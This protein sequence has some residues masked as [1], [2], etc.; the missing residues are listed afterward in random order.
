MDLS[1]ILAISGYPGLFKMIGQ[2]KG[3]VVVE[4]LI[5]GKRM[6]A[7]TTQRILSLDDITIY[8]VDGDVPLIEVFGKIAKKEKHG[9][10]LDPSKVKMDDL[11]D[12]LQGVQKDYDRE[13]VYSSDLKKL[14]VW[15]NLLAEKGLTKDAKEEEK[16]KPAKAEKKAEKKAT[17]PKAKKAKKPAA[18]K[19]D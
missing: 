7:Y 15:Y 1:G 18:K 2:T 6:P 4:S 12:Y 11:R 5:D 9:P 19:A 10:A 3:G 14:F 13:R 8:T 17:K 16:A